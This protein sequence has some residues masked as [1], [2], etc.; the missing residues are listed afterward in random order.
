MPTATDLR[1][2]GEFM[3]QLFDG[4]GNAVAD[5]FRWN[6]GWW[7]IIHGSWTTARCTAKEIQNL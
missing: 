4:M 6:N 1:T 7:K 2:Q 5:V 3:G